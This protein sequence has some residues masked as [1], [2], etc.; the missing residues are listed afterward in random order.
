MSA[1]RPPGPKGKPLVGSIPDYNRNSLRMFEDGWREYGDV[2]SFKLGPRT[3][4][5]LVNPEHLKHML[6]D[7][8]MVYFHPEWFDARVRAVIG[9]GVITKRGEDWLGRRQA[10]EPCFEAD[11][12]PPVDQPFA[13]SIATELDGWPGSGDAELTRV[14]KDDV[15]DLSVTL[16]GRV[17]FGS[18]WDRYVAAVTP[19]M[20]VF[21]E[22]V[23]RLL[24]LP[25]NVPEWLPLR[26]NRRVAAARRRFDSEFATALRSAR[27]EGSDGL[28][29]GLAELGGAHAGLSDDEICREV[30]HAFM[31]GW[32]TT[33]ASLMW[34]C[35]LLGQHPEV[36]ER[37]RAEAAEVLGDRAPASSDFE[38]MPYNRM[39]VAEIL[40]LYPPLWVGARSPVEDDEIAGYRIPAGAFV[41][42]SSYL[43]HRHPDYW[44][45][46]E[47][48]DPERWSPG[49]DE[50][51]SEWAYLP[52]SYG[53]RS[54]LG[55]EFARTAIRL[56]VTMLAQRYRLSTV[57]DHPIEHTVG[58]TLGSR[59]GV[60]VRLSPI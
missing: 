59:H 34:G 31:A 52:F 9:Q 28:L 38:R 46:P 37:L 4:Y 27:A 54:C 20:R 22:Q 55:P 48:F 19:P 39:V 26:A 23:D 18:V 15:Y 24:G 29:G 35:Y 7:L 58:I 1:P 40:R 5:L 47:S 43:T 10:L 42:Y 49:R 56:F 21:L 41:S 17:L 50:P 8:P 53:P 45:D 2:V 44:T 6:E 13:E 25:F 60:K 3:L 51:R 36:M 32:S 16:I 12:L 14:V 11:R 57:E 33:A 30:K